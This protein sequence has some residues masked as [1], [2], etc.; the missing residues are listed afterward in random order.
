MNKIRVVIQLGSNNLES[1]VGIFTNKAKYKQGVKKLIKDAYMEDSGNLS[2][3]E[4][5]E[6]I[7]EAQEFFLKHGEMSYTSHIEIRMVELDSSNLNEIKFNLL[8]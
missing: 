5:R 2:P 8:K 4:E 3:E 1:V 6:R 7:K